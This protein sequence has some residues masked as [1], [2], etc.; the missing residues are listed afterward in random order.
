MTSQIKN[1]Q[2]D[3]SNILIQEESYFFDNSLE[4][5]INDL[6]Y[7]NKENY[8]SNEENDSNNDIEEMVV[9]SKQIP[10]IFPN[11]KKLFYR[12]NSSKEK[13]ESE[14]IDCGQNINSFNI[15][16]NNTN[17]KNDVDIQKSF[18]RKTTLETPNKRNLKIEILNIILGEDKRTLIAL[19]NLPSKF[20]KK[21][22]KEEIDSKGFKG[23]YNFIYFHKIKSKNIVNIY[24]NFIHEFH[25]ISF[26][27]L[28]N[29]KKMNCID[30]IIS[31]K[32][33]NLDESELKGLIIKENLIEENNINIFQQIEIPLFYLSFFKKIYINSVCIIKEKNFYN[34][35]S[36]IVK[37]F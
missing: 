14:K 18:S 21:N 16:N 17:K 5:E 27:H 12:N 37:K 25:I 34:E 22:F 1:N 20:K 8:I 33:C 24:I 4:F 2:I 29:G 3:I 36:F 26:Y 7:E 32:Y 30:K 11:T 23:K 13:E 28:F 19:D 15:M 10:K 35:G 31:I 9:N 6:I